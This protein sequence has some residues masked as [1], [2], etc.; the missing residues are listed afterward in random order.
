LDNH[1]CTP[2][3]PGAIA[4]LQSKDYTDKYRAPGVTITL[5]GIEF[6]RDVVRLEAA[7]PVL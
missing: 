4:R 1:Q 5:V 3:Q 6:S 7:A 2:L